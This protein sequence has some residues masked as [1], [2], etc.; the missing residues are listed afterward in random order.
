ML[1]SDSI[2]IETNPKKIEQINSHL[3][4]LGSLD[5]EEKDEE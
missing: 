2:E 3:E 5:L 1:I 4:A